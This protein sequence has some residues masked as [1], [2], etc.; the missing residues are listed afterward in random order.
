MTHNTVD[1]DAILNHAQEILSR[2]DIEVERAVVFGSVARNDHTTT[3]DVDI[4]LV[5]RDFEGV[6]GANRG[7]PFRDAWN[8][9]E[10]GS[11]DF[12]EY[13]P[14]EYRT[15]RDRAGGIIQTAEAE[16]IRIV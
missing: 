5:S 2:V 15:Y 9:E 4:I 3:S 6:P 7:K 1:A 10:Y 16:G 13:T 8:Y 11:V 12:I 14:A